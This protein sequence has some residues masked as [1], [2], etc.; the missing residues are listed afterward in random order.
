M[1]YYSTVCLHVRTTTVYLYKGLPCTDGVH[2]A[3]DGEAMH[4]QGRRRGGAPW[5]VKE[6]REKQPINMI[7]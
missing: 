7:K 3:D 4:R 5:G 2:G 6:N 1:L